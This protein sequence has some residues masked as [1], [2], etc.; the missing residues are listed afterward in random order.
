[1][2]KVAKSLRV[3]VKETPSKEDSNFENLKE[4]EGSLKLQ[5][6]RKKELDHRIL[7][8]PLLII[9]LRLRDT[10]LHTEYRYCAVYNPDHQPIL[11]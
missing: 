2:L 5:R 1:L 4:E 8:L 7:L 3:R 6:T 11:Q 10:E 9:H